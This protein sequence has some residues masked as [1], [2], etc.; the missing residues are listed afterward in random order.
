MS[1]SARVYTIVSTGDPAGALAAI[2]TAPTPPDLC[3]K[4]PS[5][6]ASNLAEL[7]FGDRYI[8][9]IDEPL[10]ASRGASESDADF[11]DRCAEALLVLYALDT[12]SAFVITDLF[13]DAAGAVIVV[14]E[15]SLLRVSERIEKDVNTAGTGG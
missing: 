8:R 2:A 3:V 13:A 10:L 9:M 11:A 7:V 4:A 12:R 5:E 1:V 6:R 14:D 15:T